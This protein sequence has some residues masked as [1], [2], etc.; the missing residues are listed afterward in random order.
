MTITNTTEFT[1]TLALIS[2]IEEVGKNNTPKCYI[3]VTEKGC[4]DKE[5]P[6]SIKIDVFG[7]K[8]EYLSSYHP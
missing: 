2:D 5:Y 7:D 8:T 6:N 3:I 1:G 4:T